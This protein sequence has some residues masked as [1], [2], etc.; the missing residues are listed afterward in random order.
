MSRTEVA[1]LL[2]KG[3]IRQVPLRPAVC[4]PLTVAIQ[5]NFITKKSKK[6]KDNIFIYFC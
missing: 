2:E 5:S 1:S 6:R 4:N 3:I